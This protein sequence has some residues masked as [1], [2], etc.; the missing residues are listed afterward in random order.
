MLN[1]LVSLY[2]LHYSLTPLYFSNI[3]KKMINLELLESQKLLWKKEE[4]K[5][6]KKN[7]KIL[8]FLYK[9]AAN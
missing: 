6:K 1:T 8:N 2:S 7:I 4:L 3:K 5:V 9:I